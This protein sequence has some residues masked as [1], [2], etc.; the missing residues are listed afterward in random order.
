MSLRYLGI[1]TC[2]TSMLISP[3]MLQ[4]ADTALQS[5]AGSAVSQQKI[6]DL[7]LH[8]DGTVY[9]QVFDVNGNGAR[10]VAVSIS[11]NGRA[12]AETSTDVQGRF[13]IANLRPGVHEVTVGQSHS[14]YS[15]WAPGTAPPTAPR[16]ISVA[17]T[18]DLIV[19]GQNCGFWTRERVAMMLIGIGAVIAIG[20][21]N[22]DDQDEPSS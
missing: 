7:A 1:V 22:G 5:F 18:P 14:L 16:G 3:S 21:T 2:C 17:V 12:V 6:S 9:G 11:H 20:F 13:A 10:G 8:A 19:R 4:A 15:F